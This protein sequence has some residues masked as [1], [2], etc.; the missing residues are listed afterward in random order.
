MN[1]ADLFDRA[2]RTALFSVAAVSFGFTAPGQASNL[3]D[4]PVLA[5]SNGVLDIMMIAQ[6][7]V[8]TGFSAPGFTPTGWVYTVCPRPASGTSCP[9]GSGTVSPYGGVRLALQAG[10]LLKIRLVNNL[11]VVTEPLERA[12]EDPLLP[13]NPT[14]LHTHGLIVPASANTV[15]P[16]AIPVYGDF[17]YTSVFNP[18]NPNPV[19]YN[20]GAYQD[21]HTHGDIVTTGVVDYRIQTTANHPSGAF[22]F[23]P[24]VH[25]IALNQL[26]AGLSG[27]ISIG[28]AGDYACTDEEC[29]NPVPESAVRHI[30]LKDMEV[31]P[32]NQ[33]KFQEDPAFCA[34]Q[35]AGTPVANGQCAGDPGAYSGGVWFFTLNGQQYPTILL[36]SANGEIWRFTNTSGSASYDLQLDDDTTGQPIPFQILS[37]DGVS[38]S[39]PQGA[40]AGQ[41]AQ[42]GA[43]RFKVASCGSHLRGFFKSKPVCA[44]DLFVMPATRVEVFVAYRNAAGDVVEAPGGQTATLKTVGINTGPGGDSWPAINLGHVVF[45]QGTPSIGDAL[46]LRGG[47]AAYLSRTGGIFNTPVPGASPAPLPPGCQALAPGHHRRLYFANPNVPGGQG[48]GNDPQGNAIFGI[49]YEEV[50]QNGVT[51]PGTFVD[52]TQFNPGAQAVTPSANLAQIICLPLNPGQYP[53]TE[54]WELINLATELH[55]FHIHQTKYTLIDPN[56]ASGSPLYLNAPQPGVAEDTAPLPFAVP[57]PGKGSQPDLNPAATS[58]LISDYK[59]GLCTATPIFVHIPFARLGTFVFHCHILEHEDGGMMH[60]IRVVPSPI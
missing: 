40:T 34:N 44:T 11:P 33:T 39:F 43:N 7:S 15:A 52:V 38:V 26:S 29:E 53:V 20:P 57:I 18:A 4:P 19:T 24:H 59:N 10:D 12:N 45:P 32:G 6:S 16:P 55:N 30:I 8:V 48:P 13:L 28:H 25:G 56:A 22:W 47:H 27:I 31:L 41:V 42:I 36:G 17:V 49:G 3:L 60:A 21:Q 51:A 46:H 2:H 9:A 50:D 37:I 23:H 5:S 58:C 54:T 14:N 1:L 35:P